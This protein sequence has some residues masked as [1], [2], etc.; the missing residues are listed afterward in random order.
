MQEGPGSHLPVPVVSAVIPTRNRPD[1]VVRAVH[2]ALTQTYKNLEVIV[3]IDGPDPATEGALTQ[4]DDPRLRVVALAESVGGAEARN[5]GVRAARGEWIAFLDDDDEW[6]P[7]KT[8]KQLS[9]VLTS[10]FRH[11]VGACRLIARRDG[12]DEIW[13]RRKPENGE[14]MSEYLLCRKSLTYGDGIIQT[15]TIMAS[16]VL[17]STVPFQRG[18]PRHH[19]W[20]WILRATAEGGATVEWV[21]EPLVIFNLESGRRSINRRSSWIESLDWA[22]RTPT[23]TKRS[24]AYLAAIQIAPRLNIFRDFSRLPRLSR[25]LLK[26]GALDIRAI[27]Y[28]IVFFVFPNTLLKKVSQTMIFNR[29]IVTSPDTT[30]VAS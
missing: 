5:T 28:G 11:P 21:W 14:P 24:V 12:G 7:E 22:E 17:L 9:T 26:R 20:D 6:L 29:R 10:A 30:T 18:L 13:P 3:V 23:L 27:V 16:K 8:D 15:S 19:D 2:S 4:V 1:L 25:T